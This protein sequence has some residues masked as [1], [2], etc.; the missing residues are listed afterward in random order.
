MTCIDQS[1]RAQHEALR[2]REQPEEDEVVRSLPPDTLAAGQSDQGDEHDHH[3]QDPELGM[4]C[5]IFLDTLQ[6]EDA[7]DG[8]RDDEL[9]TENGI[10]LPDESKSDRLL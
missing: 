4:N 7:D 1:D 9:H 5:R 6:G 3:G 10:N 2:Q 8:H